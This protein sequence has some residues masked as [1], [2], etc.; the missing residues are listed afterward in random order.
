M[1]KDM[2]ILPLLQKGTPKEIRRK[3]GNESE[4]TVLQTLTPVA[5]LDVSATPA[6]LLIHPPLPP[7]SLPTLVVD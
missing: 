1:E 3:E 4:D 2:R 6:A 5:E 7:P